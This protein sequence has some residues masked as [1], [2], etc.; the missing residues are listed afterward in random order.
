MPWPWRPLST[1]RV[2]PKVAVPQPPRV[3]AQKVQRP[4]RGR[5]V[6]EAEAEAELVVQEAAGVV[7]Q[8]EVPHRRQLKL[9]T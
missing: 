9:S 7:G 8:V 1:I 4:P 5:V 6:A 2:A 3:E